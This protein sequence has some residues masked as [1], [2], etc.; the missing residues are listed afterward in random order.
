MRDAKP[1]GHLFHPF[2]WCF[3]VAAASASCTIMELQEPLPAPQTRS[4]ASGAPESPAGAP[5]VDPRAAERLDEMGRFL[6]DQKTFIVKAHVTTDQ[7]LESGQTIQVVSALDVSVARPAGLHAIISA[8]WTEQQF[9]YDG[10]TFTIYA[11][12]EGYYATVDAPSTLGELVGFASN[13]YGI[14]L[15]LVDLFRSGTDRSEAASLEAASDLG[16]S[17]VDDV[18]CEHYAFRQGHVSWEVWIEQGARPLPH[19]LVITTTA[20]PAQPPHEVTYE[21][22]LNAET[23]DSTFHFTPPKGAHKIPLEERGAKPGEK[24]REAPQ[25]QRISSAEIILGILTAMTAI[26]GDR[27]PVL[28]PRDTSELGVGQN[29]LEVDIAGGWARPVVAG[30]AIAATATGTSAAIGSVVSS[31]PRGCTNNV[32]A[33]VT[34]QHCGSTWYQPRYSGT[35]II[36]VI[37]EPP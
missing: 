37:V 23:P 1:S 25:Q 31:V 22:T 6:R 19:R 21:W 11:P 27:T 36:Y 29:I 35:R 18:P 33:G 2:L 4:Q 14:E 32:V 34:F 28:R 5:E 30:T 15:P 3:A 7:T 12:R 20:T 26:R 13:R 24:A 8:D 17:T 9:Y 16:A 10:T